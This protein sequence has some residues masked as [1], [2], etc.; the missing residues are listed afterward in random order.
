MLIA[1][2]DNALFVLNKQPNAAGRAYH[3]L[4]KETWRTHETH[5]VVN[6]SPV[7]LRGFKGDYTINIK[8]NGHVIKSEQFTL[9]TKGI[10]LEIHLSQHGMSFRI[11]NVP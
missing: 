2:L 5:N 11:D 9:G 6:H 8:Q 4:F 7:H 1:L 10:S 3:K